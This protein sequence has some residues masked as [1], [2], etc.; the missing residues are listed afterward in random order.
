MNPITEFIKEN[1]RLAVDI[2]YTTY[3]HIQ[4]VTCM[5]THHTPFC[6]HLHIVCALCVRATLPEVGMFQSTLA[7]LTSLLNVSS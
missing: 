7:F 4:D 2:T 1:T 3:T 5:D 6:R